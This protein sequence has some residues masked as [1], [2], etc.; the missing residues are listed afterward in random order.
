[1]RISRWP[2]N[3]TC[4]SLPTITCPRLTNGSSN[5]E[6]NLQLRALLHKHATAVAHVAVQL[7]ARKRR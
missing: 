4:A 7:A 6:L 2:P 3:S 5:T 1:M